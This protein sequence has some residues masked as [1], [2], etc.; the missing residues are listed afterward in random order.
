MDTEN[1]KDLLVKFPEEESSLEKPV[2]TAI[3]ATPPTP[4]N[5]V[6]KVA[7]FLPRALNAVK[8]N[9]KESVFLFGMLGYVFIAAFGHMEKM[10]NYLGFFFVFLV[11]IVFYKLWDKI[12]LKNVLYLLIIIIILLINIFLIKFID[13]MSN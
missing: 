1:K 5:T 10:Q 3:N 12:T 8:D 13:C 2:E 6:D 9:F 11:G 7:D 4:N